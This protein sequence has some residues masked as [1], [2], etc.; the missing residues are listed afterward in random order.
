[1]A[2]AFQLG[3][4]YELLVSER[5]SKLMINNC[6]LQV[7]PATA[8]ATTEN[9]VR[10]QIFDKTI[11][12]ECKTKGGFEGGGTKFELVDDELIIQKEGILK[13]L[14]G[15]YS[16]YDGK[17]PSF[18]R[19]D[20]SYDTWKVEKEM[21]SDVYVNVPPYSVAEYYRLKG[22]SYIQVEGKGLYHT[23][24]DVLELG[25]PLFEVETKMRMRTSKHINRKTGVP[26]DVTIA[27]VFNRRTL[28]VTPICLVTRV[29]G[30]K[31][32]MIS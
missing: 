19:G 21:F 29:E 14:L 5:L 16:P 10:F 6:P 1:M 12:I 27:L 4:A 31:F 8:G 26:T 20:K 32:Q 7:F 2:R 3:H 9:D 25:V 23:G 13:S 24:I 17:I 11:G 22:S 30:S 18:M 15:N 28:P